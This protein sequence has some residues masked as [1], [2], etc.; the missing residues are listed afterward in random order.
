LI[1][2]EFKFFEKRRA[3]YKSFDDFEEDIDLFYS[4]YMEK[5]PDF[6]NRK[7]IIL[8]FLTKVLKENAKHFISQVTHKH[9]SKELHDHHTPHIQNRLEE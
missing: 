5:C 7:L 8:E 6:E 1:L 2:K 3:E 4:F 9:S